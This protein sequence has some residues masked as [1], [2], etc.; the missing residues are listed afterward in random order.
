MNVSLIGRGSAEM[1]A[2]SEFYPTLDRQA[3]IAFDH[4]V[5]HFDRAAHGIDDAAELNESAVPGSLDDAPV[6][7]GDGRVE[8]VAAQRT[9]PRQG[10]ILVRAGEPAIADHV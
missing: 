4:A 3:R 8:Q 10:A 5:L 7:Q 2:D 6:M 1:N 9:Q